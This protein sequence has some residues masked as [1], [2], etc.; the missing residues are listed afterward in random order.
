MKKNNFRKLL[1]VVN[2]C[3]FTGIFLFAQ[4]Q[5]NKKVHIIV[6]K[7]DA[8]TVDT[9]FTIDEDMDK[10]EIQKMIHEL[11]GMD[12][13]VSHGDKMAH[14]YAFTS[15]DSADFDADVKEMEIKI[16]VGDEGERHTVIH[17]HGSDDHMKWVEHKSGDHYII[18]EDEDGKKKKSEIFI[19]SGEYEG[20]ENK[21]VKKVVHKGGDMIM[22]TEEDVH[23][24][25]KGN[26]S[27][28]K[29]EIDGKKVIVLESSEKPV[30]FITKDGKELEL[31]LKDKK[32]GTDI[33]LDEVK[34]IVIETS[35]D[36]VINIIVSDK[37]EKEAQKKKVN[38]KK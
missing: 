11:T 21:V 18:V 29:K 13:K 10:D 28:R 30:Y 31:S 1:F 32:S 20:D 36:G 3:L 8:T 17:K 2:L 19:V 9:S 25:D 37:K 23:K 38:K 15:K 34:V 4:E 7:N 33:A 26:F 22:I 35:E 6:K 24:G 5:E 12:V 16:S 27:I 14:A